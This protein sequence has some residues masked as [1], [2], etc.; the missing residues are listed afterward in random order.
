A[1]RGVRGAA[2][3]RVA[4]ADGPGPAAGRLRGAAGAAADAGRR[5]RG[6]SGDRAPRPARP[7][8][9]SAGPDPRLTITRPVVGPL[10][11]SLGRPAAARG[12]R[13]LARDGEL[14]CAAALGPVA[15]A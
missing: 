3:G 4:A 2:Q 5:L 10:G 12:H 8:P 11:S 15:G 9:P 1:G 13:A 6:L 7:P 14:R